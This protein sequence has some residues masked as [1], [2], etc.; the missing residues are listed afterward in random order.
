MAIRMSITARSIYDAENVFICGFAVGVASGAN[1]L[2]IETNIRREVDPMHVSVAIDMANAF[3]MGKRKFLFKAFS[4]FRK[5]FQQPK[6]RIDV[7]LFQNCKHC[8][9]LVSRLLRVGKLRKR[10]G[11]TSHG[12]KS[13]W[14][15]FALHHR[16]A[17]ISSIVIAM[18]PFRLI[19]TSR[20]ALF[21][22]LVKL[23]VVPRE[24]RVVP[25]GVRAKPSPNFPS[26]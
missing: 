14:N 10:E 9:F 25:R 20:R 18:P 11:S 15:L 13:T 23:S 7:N 26:A 1:I 4:R 17:F 6:D 21:W 2:G 12:K 3:N 22:S 5:N 16:V 8:I 24:T 19:L